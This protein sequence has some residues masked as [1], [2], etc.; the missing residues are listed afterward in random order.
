[1]IYLL[2]GYNRPTS[3][4]LVYYLIE[5]NKELCIDGDISFISVEDMMYNIHHAHRI[6]KLT[7]FTPL[8]NEEI[9]DKFN[10]MEELLEKYIEYAI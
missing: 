4:I 8:F 5:D 9:V 6:V 1:M 10:N 7:R 3:K 2:K